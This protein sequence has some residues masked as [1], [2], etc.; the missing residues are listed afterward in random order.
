EQV[1]TNLAG[2]AELARKM[3]AIV[4]RLVWSE[5]AIPYLNGTPFVTQR[6]PVAGL[7]QGYT[8]ESDNAGDE[9]D[10]QH[11]Y[12]SFEDTFRGSEEFI[13]DRQRVYLSI[14]DGREPVL[15]FGCGRGEFLDLLLDRGLQYVGV[16]IDGGMIER[17]LQKGHVN[18]KQMD[19][20]TY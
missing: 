12:R 4:Q 14:V 6:N 19:G 1:N 5:Q 3:D 11:L 18:V 16:D 13:R 7:V 20:L 17:C 9:D 8:D 2:V 10:H 15:D